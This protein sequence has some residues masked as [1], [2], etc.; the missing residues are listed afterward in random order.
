MPP[1]TKANINN[2]LNIPGPELTKRDEPAPLPKYK[3]PYLKHKI[4]G[5]I[6]LLLFL[7]GILGNAL[8]GDE[9]PEEIKGLISQANK[10]LSNLPFQSPPP[11]PEI[12]KNPQIHHL[13]LGSINNQS[14]IYRT[15]E[16]YKE[17][18][19]E[20]RSATNIPYFGEAL[21]A[22]SQNYKTV[23]FSDIEK[24]IEIF[25]NEDITINKV[26]QYFV[27]SSDPNTIFLSIISPGS[28]INYVGITQRLYKTNKMTGESRLILAHEVGSEKYDGGYG[29]I[30]IEEEYGPSH[31]LLSIVRCLTEDCIAKGPV[32][33]IVINTLSRAERYHTRVG[34]FLFHP[35]SKEYT[36]RI[37][38]P[39]SDGDKKF[40]KPIGSE[41]RFTLP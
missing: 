3:D 19:N 40:Y 10:Q 25:F 31:L 39:F 15:D 21:D 27:S 13:Y 9:A 34:G 14:V 6:I 36:V 26:E 18:N 30:K 7:V 37:L 8:I 20:R 24:P 33:H 12:V 35:D 22:N 5:A 2:P 23:P 16:E 29:K 32:G 4:A 41:S 11:T 1:E 28:S 38:I 17:L